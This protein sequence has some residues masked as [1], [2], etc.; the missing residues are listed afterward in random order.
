MV[1]VLIVLDTSVTLNL[2][3]TAISHAVL[4][5]FDVNILACSSVLAETRYIRSDDRAQPRQAVSIDPWIQ[6]GTVKIV[7]PELPAN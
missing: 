5:S 7:S 4:D 3:A 6:A 2:L 1:S